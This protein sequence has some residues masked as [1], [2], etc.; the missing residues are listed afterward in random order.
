MAVVLLLLLVAVPIIELAAFVYVAGHIGILA[1]AALVVL[2]SIGGIALVK[3]EGLGVW[4]S[5][6]TRL[7]AGETPT[8]ELLNG[9]LVL[10]AGLLMAVPGFVTDV[11]GLLLLIP[12]I[13]ALVRT[14]AFGRFERRLRAAVVGGPGGMTFG[15]GDLGATNR[16]GTQPGR[17][18]TGP[19]TY[20]VVDVHEVDD[21]PTSGGPHHGGAGELEP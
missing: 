2:C 20:G 8:T 15:V 14:V 17:T 3:R 21:D 13:R 7:Q 4:R 11:L 12:P 16:G 9:L 1:A 10:V 6:Q 5:A 19:A 18:F